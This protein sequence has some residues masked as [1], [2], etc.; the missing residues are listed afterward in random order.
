MNNNI[1]HLIKSYINRIIKLTFYKITKELKCIH[2]VECV[3]FTTYICVEFLFN[4]FL[5][6][7]HF[8]TRNYAQV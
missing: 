6:I 1:M 8:S 4:F 5:L 2:S 7:N 3:G